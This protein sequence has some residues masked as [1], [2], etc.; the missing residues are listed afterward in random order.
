MKYHFQ[1]LTMKVKRMNL[2]Q[3]C[4]DENQTNIA[5]LREE[6]SPVIDIQNAQNTVSF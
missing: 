2:I 3:R 1:L 5:R 6:K 4:I